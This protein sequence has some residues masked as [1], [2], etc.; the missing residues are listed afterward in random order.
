[1]TTEHTAQPEEHA[2][3]GWDQNPSSWPQRIPIVLLALV[4]FVIAAYLSAYQLRWIDS[5][6]DPFF[7]EQSAEILDSPVS[8]VLPLPDAALGALGYLADAVTGVLGGRERY[9]KMPWI[10]VLFGLAVGPLGATSI[11]LVILQPVA[12]N[13]WCTLCL[14]TAAISIIM[15]PPAMDEVLASAQHL[16]RVRRRGGSVWLAFLGRADAEREL[17]LTHAP[18]GV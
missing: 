17:P 7:G 18:S 10:V 4:G 5:V 9:R 2:P 15:I 8:R 6:W 11:L 16:A 14:A 1:M 12:F 3:P 13:A